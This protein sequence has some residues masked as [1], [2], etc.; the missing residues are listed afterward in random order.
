MDTEPPA[1]SIQIDRSDKSRE[2]PAPPQ[3][4]PIGNGGIRSLS[5]EDQRSFR[6]RLE[7]LL[8]TLEITDT[9]RDVPMRSF[10]KWRMQVVW[11]LNRHLGALHPYTV[12]FIATV[13]RE[14]DPYSNGRLVIAGQAILEALLSDF[15]EGQ[16]FHTKA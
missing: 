9:R 3:L 7:Q 1:L 11:F 12:E 4:D 13:D 2:S 14:A 5:P 15:D 8:T 10:L 16:V 6:N